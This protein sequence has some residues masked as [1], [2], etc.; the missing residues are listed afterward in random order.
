MAN[1]HRSEEEDIS[2]GG[3][4]MCL[5]VCLPTTAQVAHRYDAFK[6]RK[7]TFIEGL[8]RRHLLGDAFVKVTLQTRAA[9]RGR[10]L[11]VVFILFSYFS[12]MRTSSIVPVKA[13]GGL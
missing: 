5:A 13:K 2:R 12:S 3:C 4:A 10:C 11:G 8:G 6:T 9:A 1:R 7:N